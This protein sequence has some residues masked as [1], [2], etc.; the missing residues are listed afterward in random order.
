VPCLF[1][2]KLNKFAGNWMVARCSGNWTY[3]FYLEK[4]LTRIEICGPYWRS[5]IRRFDIQLG[6]VICFE[7]VEETNNFDIQVLNNADEEKQQ[8]ASF[9]MA[10]YI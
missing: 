3:D 8:V 1:R 5:F 4:T 2:E 7:Y 10:H 6:D 9:G